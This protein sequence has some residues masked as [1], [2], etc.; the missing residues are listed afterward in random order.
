MTRRQFVQMNIVEQTTV[1][2]AQAKQL[3]VFGFLVGERTTHSRAPAKS[4][5]AL[6]RR[7]GIYRTGCWRG[8][9]VPCIRLP[10]DSNSRHA[11]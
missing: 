8:L 7:K 3:K 9:L 11:R 1:G 6:V 2:A 10:A 4:S 5:P